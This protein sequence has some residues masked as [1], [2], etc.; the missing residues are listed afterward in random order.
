MKEQD[1]NSQYKQQ[2]N[3]LHAPKD[4]IAHTKELAAREK[5]SLVLKK[6][7][8]R[9]LY[10]T[11]SLAAAAVLLFC[12]FVP[13]MQKTEEKTEE[14]TKIHLGQWENG[15]KIYLEDKVSLDRTAVLPLA[16][17]DENTW[18]E[19]VCGITVQFV[20][21]EGGKFMAAFREQDAYVVISSEKTDKAAFLKLITKLLSE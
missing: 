21:D 18:E 19:E 13:G 1:F 15:K 17:M 20:Q 10:A 11:A 3:T 14:G 9:Y 4:L 5:E 8:F 12:I 6:R 16:F 2:L 7:R